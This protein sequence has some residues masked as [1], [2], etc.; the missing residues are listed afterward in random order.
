MRRQRIFFTEQFIAIELGTQE[1]GG[2][3]VPWICSCR[4]VENSK[5]QELLWSAIPNAK[6]KNKSTILDKLGAYYNRIK[7]LPD[8]ET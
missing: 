6:K 4:T 2:S 1:W 3:D 5:Y 7:Y 8:A